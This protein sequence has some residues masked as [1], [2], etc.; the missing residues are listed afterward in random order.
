MLNSPSVQKRQQSARLKECGQNTV[1]PEPSA[2][3]ASSSFG[4]INLGLTSAMVGESAT[5]LEP[6]LDATET[7]LEFL[8]VA[9]ELGSEGRHAL[10]L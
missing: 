7:G 1:E 5:E 6:E 4:V 10:D 8:D 3:S 9:K 2:F